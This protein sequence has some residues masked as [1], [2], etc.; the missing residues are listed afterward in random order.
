MGLEPPYAACSMRVRW[1]PWID[2]PQLW[3]AL[4]ITT[5]AAV[6][7]LSRCVSQV[8]SET[9][10]YAGYQQFLLVVC[11]ACLWIVWWNIGVGRGISGAFLQQHDSR[12]DRR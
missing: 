11:R 1:I 2:C 12:R 9:S 3:K 7:G 10:G 5:K 8:G 4:W 6:H